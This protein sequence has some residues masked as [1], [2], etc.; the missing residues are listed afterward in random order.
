MNQ[1]EFIAWNHRMFKKYNN[2]RLYYHPNPIVRWIESLRLKKI[3]G[4]VKLNPKDKFLSLGCGE[5][6]IE[7]RLSSGQL[8]LLDLSVEAIARAKH[9]MVGRENVKEIKI[10]DALNIEYP[11]NFFDFI[12][13]S[14]VIEHVLDYNRLINEISRVARPGAQII[15]TIPNEKKIDFIKNLL[16]KT[17]VFSIL[18]KNIPVKQEW[19]LH[20]FDLALLK[21]STAGKLNILTAAP[22]PNIFLPLRYVCLLKK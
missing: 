5:A 8:Y 2:E 13:C 11:D 1:Q 6:Y 4:L 22:I 7:N 3:L 15:I 14:E 20:E 9:K 19:H 21:K 17:R 16:I 10:G 12:L 18:F